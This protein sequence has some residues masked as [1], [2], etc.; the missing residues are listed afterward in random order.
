MNILFNDQ[1]CG[2]FNCV[3][4]DMNMYM[5]SFYGPLGPFENVLGILLLS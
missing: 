3:C 1:S 4:D 5:G 2:E